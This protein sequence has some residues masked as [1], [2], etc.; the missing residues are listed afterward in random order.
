MEFDIDGGTDDIALGNDAKWSEHLTGMKLGMI[1]QQMICDGSLQVKHVPE[2][3]KALDVIGF[4]WVN[5]R[6]F[7]N[8]PF[9]KAMCAM[10]V[11]FLIRVDLFLYKDYVMMMPGEKPWSK[12]LA[13]YKLGKAVVGIRELQNFFKAYHPEKV[14]L[15]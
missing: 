9:E 15:L 12:A 4:D 1:M 5:P 10:F 14:R 13:G 6:K 2:Q 11:Y 3:K 7:I 8:V